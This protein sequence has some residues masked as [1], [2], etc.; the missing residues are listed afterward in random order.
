MIIDNV[1]KILSELP[2]GVELIAAA[3]SRT[4]AE[5]LEAIGAGVR[6]I[7]ENYVQEAESKF[8]VVGNKPRWHLIG[9]LQGNK[10]K[11]AVK[12][13]DCIETVDSTALAQVIDKECVKINKVME[14]MIEVNS[15][16]EAQKAGCLPQDVFAL[17]KAIREFKNIRLIGLMTMGSVEGGDEL[18]SQFKETKRIFEEIKRDT[19]TLR[20]LSMG[21]SLSYKMAIEEG[22]NM[23]RLGTLLFGARVA[24]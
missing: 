14:V 17:A 12:I 9:H 21:M 5:I 15:G 11:K 20:Y 22:A 1:K 4:P 19:I 3:K 10:A 8:A 6:I 16:R 2:K 7:G 13:F 24:K 18:R 23:V